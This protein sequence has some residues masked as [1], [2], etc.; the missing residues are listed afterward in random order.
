ML[1]VALKWLLA[2]AMVLSGVMHFTSSRTYEQ[3]MPRWL[4]AHHAL[5]LI[6]G[7][8]EVAGGVGLLIPATQMI[9]AWGLIA[10][11]VAIFPANVNMAVNHLP[12]GGKP[13]PGWALWLRLPLQLVF[14]G[15]AWLFTR[16]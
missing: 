1:F 7:F 11:F 5:V 8:C 2:A 10:L 16:A 6:S 3:M 15:W 13:V 4:P 12:L 14:I 9:A